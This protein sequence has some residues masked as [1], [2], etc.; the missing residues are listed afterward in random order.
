MAKIFVISG[1]AGAG[2]RSV[3][4]PIME[5][6]PDLWYSV[7]VT[8]RE[9]RNGKGDKDIPGVTYHFVDEILFKK[10]FAADFFLEHNCFEGN[11]RFYGTPKGAFSEH[12]SKGDDI[13]MEIDVNGFEQVLEKHPDAIGIFIQPDSADS[14]K[15][16]IKSRATESDE[17]IAKRLALADDEFSKINLYKYKITNVFGQPEKAI[18]ECEAIIK[19]ER[20]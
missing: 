20:N 3:R 17:E 10:M 9:P 13:L 1:S 4:E 8:T 6:F 5:K 16:Q 15:N 11:H 19:K 2:K 7:S 18:A 14:H 12:Y